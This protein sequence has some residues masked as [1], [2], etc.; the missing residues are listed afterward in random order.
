MDLS[1][2]S[3]AEQATHRQ[4][5]SDLQAGRPL[6]ALRAWRQLLSAEPERIRTHLKHGALQL[7]GNPIA[8]VKQLALDLFES[9]LQG[10][11]GETEQGQ[12]GALLLQLGK[13]S[14]QELPQQAQL[15]FE[16]AWACSRLPEAA[17]HLA[18]LYAHQGLLEGAWAMGD[19]ASAPALPPWQ[20]LPC[21]PGQCLP[22][23][24]QLQDAPATSISRS[25]AQSQEPLRRIKGGEIW[26]QRHTNPWRFSH[27]V[28]CVD[29]S[30][31]PQLDH[32]RLYPWP[33]ASCPH[34][35]AFAAA[36]WRRLQHH[37][38][39]LPPPLRLKGSVLAVADLS[40]E[41]YFHWMLETLPRLG[42]AWQQLQSNEPPSWVWHNG[43]DLP[44]TREA[45]RRLGIPPDRIIHA[46]T[47]PWIQAET[48]LLPPFTPFGAIDP[49]HLTWLE[50]FWAE[51]RAEA[52]AAP[53]AT[54][55]YLPRGAAGRRAVLE[56]ASLIKQLR[57]ARPKLELL[58]PTASTS[59]QLGS[60]NDAELVIAGHGSA[61]ANLLLL[62]Q[63]CD[64][65]EL[66]NPDYQPPYFNSLLH[67]RQAHHRRMPGL[68]T[69]LPLQELLY[70][71]SLSLPIEMGQ[72]QVVD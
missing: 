22:C 53:A 43:G 42:R 45:C 11:P 64:V 21:F 44:S 18:G 28:G 52:K 14:L 16:Q 68:A 40:G 60:L 67:R 70:E 56:E 26:V 46:A 61:L 69:P 2:V 63:G 24:D 9:L 32:C 20:A 25:T 66:V 31:A 5:C 27:G 12:L 29:A 54:S 36:S 47:H 30:G 50:R 17:N 59:S 65:I 23:Q 62:P 7:Q 10:E 3:A 41:L 1:S 33:W 48:L 15:R 51:P 4:A 19:P 49:G 8:P 58:A 13:I 72:I 55:H 57:Q 71:N 6:Q 34:E 38:L 39:T 35:S 37:R